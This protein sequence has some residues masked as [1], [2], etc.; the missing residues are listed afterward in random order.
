[1]GVI[2]GGGL[3]GRGADRVVDR[4]GAQVGVND[5]TPPPV[6]LSRLDAIARQF[7]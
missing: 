6:I 4:Q 2:A 3:G 5:L 1:V 7:L